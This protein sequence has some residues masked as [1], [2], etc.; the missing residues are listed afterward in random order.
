MIVVGCAQPPPTPGQ[1]ANTPPPPTDTPPEVLADSWGGG[2]GVAS[3]PVVVAPPREYSILIRNHGP[4]GPL[5][6]S[7]LRS[8]PKWTAVT[9]SEGM[10]HSDAHIKIN[11]IPFR[12]FCPE[13]ISVP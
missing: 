10:G 9:F 1:A 11:S 3:G 12:T 6:S 4:S 13:L 7:N 2:G 5:T 8:T